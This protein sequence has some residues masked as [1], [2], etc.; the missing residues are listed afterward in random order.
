LR[1]FHHQ[2]KIV[3]KTFIST[4]LFVLFSLWLF[5]FEE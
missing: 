1:S 2:A 3:R 4:V 5:V